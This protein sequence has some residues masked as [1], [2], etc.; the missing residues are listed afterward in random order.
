MDDYAYFDHD[1]DIGIIGRG[2][3]V[4]AAFE[5]AA[6]AMFSIMAEELCE[7]LHEE[8]SFLFE[9]EEM[10]FAL[11]RW[12]NLLLAHAQSRGLVLGRFSLKHEGVLWHAKAWGVPW[13]KEIVRG[14][15][16]KGATLT[17]LSVEERA[18]RWEARCIV[19]V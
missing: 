8:I 1:A 3:T 2:E 17:M 6:K 16:V 9:E 11:V 13:S 5:S 14:V 18:G 15:E 19:D 7:P 10:E 4:E 12:L